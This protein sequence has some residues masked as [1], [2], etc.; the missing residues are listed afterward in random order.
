M[1]SLWTITKVCFSLFVIFTQIAQI[2]V[3]S[4]QD[5]LIVLPC[6]GDE[7][8]EQIAEFCSALRSSDIWP[9][10]PVKLH[11]PCNSV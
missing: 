10:S 6:D 4:N 2:F 9:S 11:A 7:V 8:N 1:H 5:S 3:T